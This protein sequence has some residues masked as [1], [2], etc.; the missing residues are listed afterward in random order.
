MIRLSKS[1]IGQDEIKAI[2]RVLQDE[3]LGMGVEVQKFEEELSTFFGRETI[4]VNSGTAALQLA[5]QAT[6]I[7]RGDEVLVQSLTFLATFQ[8]ISAIGAIPIPC[9]VY[10][11]TFTIDLEDAK[12][13]IT[14]KTKAIIP[15][16]YASNVGNLDDIYEFANKYNLRIIEDAA[17]AFGT[18]YKNRRIGSFGDIACFSF[19]GIKNITSGEGGGVVSND[20]A[21]IQKIKNLRLLGVENDS[22][23]RYQNKR[24]WDFDVVEQGWR[25]HMSNIMAAIGRSQ[26]KKFDLFKAKRQ[27]LAKHYVER[28]G[29]IDGLKIFDFNYDEVV[30]HIFVVRILRGDRDDIRE[31]LQN[32]GIQTGIHYKPNHLLS[33]YKTNYTLP[34]TKKY[35][36]EILTLPLHP[37]LSLE[38]VDDVCD[39]LLSKL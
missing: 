12:S 10:E 31:K 35:Y 37:D 13:K 39:T 18:K 34:L 8:A 19:D 24:S 32:E 30:P 23:N 1:V 38:N 28:L 21:V 25:F 11:N 20:A 33:F 4:C 27:L 5:L 6:D 16:H 7:K 15:V 14:T 36:S 3:F 9:E 29:K 26:L 17:H 2:T 22:D